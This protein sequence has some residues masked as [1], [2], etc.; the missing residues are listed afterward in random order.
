LGGRVVTKISVFTRAQTSLLAG[1]T[2]EVT[3]YLN[4]MYPEGSYKG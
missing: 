4:G 3:Q 1:P 2:R